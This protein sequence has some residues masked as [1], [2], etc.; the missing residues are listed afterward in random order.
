MKVKQISTTV[1]KV[2]EN[3]PE[4]RDNDF[5]LILKVWAIQNPK[6]RNKDLTFIEFSKGFLDGKYA[7]TESIRRSRAKLQEELPELRG[8]S[9]NKRHGLQDEVK[10]DLND[11]AELY[12]NKGVAN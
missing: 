8:E 2:L 12:R 3:V 1:K 10:E 11:M 4:C 7:H 6:L 5:L 9:Y